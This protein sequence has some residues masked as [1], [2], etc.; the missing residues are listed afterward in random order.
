MGLVWMPPKIS[1]ILSMIEEKSPVL[2]KKKFRPEPNQNHVLVIG[3][4]K[5]ESLV[6]FLREFFCEDH[7]PQIVNTKVILMNETGPDKDSELLISDPLYEKSVSFILGSPSSI[8]DLDTVKAK[9]AKSIFLLSKKSHNDNDPV[10]EDSHKVL[11]TLAIK[12]YLTSKNISVPIYA[13]TM[14][15]ETAIYLRHLAKEVICIP[16]LRLGILAQG[17]QVPGFS[18][19]IQ[20][21]MTS[22]PR[23]TEKQ[24]LKIVKKKKSL[25]WLEEYIHGLGQEIYSTK[26]SPFFNGMTFSEIAKYI[27]VNFSST[28]FAIKIASPK[29]G[30]FSSTRDE[31]Q[32][33][34]SD[35]I[36]NGSEIGFII[37]SDSY[38]TLSIRNAPI[39]V[40]EE[41]SDISD[42]RDPLMGTFSNFKNDNTGISK[43][44]ADYLKGLQ[45]VLSIK[46]TQKK[47]KGNSKKKIKHYRGVSYTS[48]FDIYDGNGKLAD[49]LN[50]YNGKENY[51][52]GPLSRGK[53]MGD[54]AIPTFG[55]FDGCILKPDLIDDHFDLERNNC[56]GNFQK[57]IY[58]KN[59]TFSEEGIPSN[60]KNH[61]VICITGSSFPDN[62]EYLVGS[63]RSS[64]FGLYKQ[65]NKF[66]SSRNSISSALSSKSGIINK[67]SIGSKSNASQKERD[68]DPVFGLKSQIF[69]NPQH[70][71]FLSK[72]PPSKADRELLEKFENVYFIE[73]SP[74]SKPNMVRASISTATSALVLVN[75]N[76][77]ESDSQDEYSI[78]KNSIN[79]ATSDA[80][81]LV[82]VLNIESLTCNRRDFM[83]CVE[84]N[85]R[86]N[87]QF[88]GDVSPIVVNGEYIQS[89]FRPCF[90]SGNCYA[91]TMLDT[92]ICQSYYNENLIPLLKKIVYPRVNITKIVECSKMIDAGLSRSE[93]PRLDS[94]SNIKQNSNLHLV[95][96]PKIFIG[97]TYLSLFLE[98]SRRF[99]AIC[100][101]IYRN[102]NSVIL[103][104]KTKEPKFKFEKS[105]Y[106]SLN[107]SEYPTFYFVANP[108][109]TTELVQDDQVYIF[110]LEYPEFE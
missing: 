27:F 80:P 38:I 41:F 62:M 68:F 81:S 73:G 55:S 44:Q 47:E 107:V 19:L 89:L 37:S 110:S 15:P 12:R 28:L 34:P 40:S 46:K 45:S 3:D 18:S 20:A 84:L 76:D 83:L 7:G 86:E 67:N 14:Q 2:A 35:Y 57:E 101:G 99:G 64:S 13:Q 78:Q 108:S 54:S 91:P 8:H 17:V 39:T 23:N 87:M 22:I 11:I 58:E 16:E 71:V 6:E 63:I 82:V 43:I 60:I 97:G 42:E 66:N 98:F 95:P 74:L 56:S 33:N 29:T 50:S 69:S 52:N 88:I 96:I 32:I 102:S 77:V 21:L 31:I 24:L 75:N 9:D 36:F 72:E 100:I 53:L 85:Y 1:Q 79:I 25:F 106:D 61:I 93:I 104:K 105:D 109:Y 94:T 49:N 48:Y 92:L 26:F 4:L 65:K 10:D 30:Y 51:S 70:I 103:N 5:Y 90:M 59:V